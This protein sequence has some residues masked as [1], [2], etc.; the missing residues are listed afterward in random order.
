MRTLEKRSHRPRDI[1]VLPFKLLHD[2]IS[3]DE[4]LYAN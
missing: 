2:I 1:V 3:I 4:R